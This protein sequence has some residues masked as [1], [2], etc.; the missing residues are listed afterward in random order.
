M[1]RRAHD[2]PCYRVVF[3]KPARFL[4]ENR[5]LVCGADAA[6]LAVLVT[7][8]TLWLLGS[9]N[10]ELSSLSELAKCE[11]VIAV[12]L[13]G[14]HGL[15]PVWGQREQNVEPNKSLSPKMARYIYIYV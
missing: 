5:P 2:G 8:I 9:G 1:W 12:E 6:P 15:S 11:T 13:L 10:G 3:S 4:D 14:P 7:R